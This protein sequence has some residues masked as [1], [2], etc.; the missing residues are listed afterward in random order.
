MAGGSPYGSQS[1]PGGQKKV[2]ISMAM[3]TV[4]TKPDTASSDYQ[5]DS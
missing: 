3:L 5:A 2:L 4:G 1:S